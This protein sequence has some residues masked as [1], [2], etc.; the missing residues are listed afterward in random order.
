MFTRVLGWIRGAWRRMIGRSDV[1]KRL[2][3]DVAI[4]SDMANAIDTWSRMYTNDAAWLDADVRSLGLASAIAQEIARMITI[5]MTVECTGSARATWLQAQ[6]EK[7]GHKLPEFIEYACAKGGLIMK[8]FVAN[9]AIV[10]D[11]V[12]AD[13]FY[14]VEFDGSGNI[15]AVI[16]AD[17]K[18][19]GDR[20]YTRLEYHRQVNNA[21]E[22]INRAFR[23]SNA[24]QLGVGIELTAV[25]DWADIEPEVTFA[26]VQRPLY[27]YF[28]Y[29][30]ANHIDTRSPLGVSCYSRAAELIEDADR[31]YGRYKW[32]YEGGEL[33]LHVDE[34]AMGLGSDGLP[35]LPNKRLYRGLPGAADL[36][37]S[38]LFQSWAPQLRDEAYNRGLQTMIQR[39]EF[40]CGLAYGTISDPQMV[41]K[42]ATEIAASK[43]R[44]QST[45]ANGQKALEFA[46]N[47]LFYAMDAYATMYNLAPAGTYTVTQSYDDSLI[48]D[49]ETQFSQDQRVVTMG[50]MAKK[51]FLMRNYNL[52]EQDAENWIVEQQ[53]ET[54]MDFFGIDS[55]GAKSSSPFDS[56]IDSAVDNTQRGSADNNAISLLNDPA[57]SPLNGA[58]ITSAVTLL[59]SVREGII[60]PEVAYELLLALGIDE[61]SVKRM[62]KDMR[63]AGV[64]AT[65]GA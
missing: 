8:P 65:D 31:Q 37:N 24:D 57:M 33:A 35:T 3:V 54:P 36:G 53:K 17:Q 25:D 61:A 64:L 23:S 22:V 48:T 62:I 27:G 60:P 63:S 56:G 44:S 47:Q 4:S 12:Q 34:M 42:T 41:E 51:R 20:Y 32:E 18:Q 2:N 16:F 40:N 15:T 19:I 5:E 14:P 55:Q 30:L 26:P 1:K 10:V 45:I 38:E 58:Q 49:H 52:S 28:R 39:I 7:F 13:Q 9:D 29:P 46:L 50:A 11:F 6:Y 43:Q 21:I 59:T